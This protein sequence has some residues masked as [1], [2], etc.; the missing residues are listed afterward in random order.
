MPATLTAS[1]EEKNEPL[2]PF[3]A[4]D[5]ADQPA[6]AASGQNVAQVFNLLYRRFPIGSPSEVRERVWIRGVRRLEALRHS[7]LGNLRYDFVTSLGRGR[8]EY[9]GFG[10]ARP[11]SATNAPGPF[12]L[13]SAGETNHGD[14]EKTELTHGKVFVGRIS[15]HRP[16][17]GFDR[18]D[19]ISSACLRDLCVSV[20]KTNGRFEVYCLTAA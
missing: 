2:P 17:E 8:P 16:G 7:R 10:A 13:N 9:Q 5:K 4:V 11:A 1:K 12:I 18:P 3:R 14:P 15:P 20:V 6:A 19:R